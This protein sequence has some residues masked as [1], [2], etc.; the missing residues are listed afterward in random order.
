MV[1]KDKVCIIRKRFWTRRKPLLKRN[2]WPEPYVCTIT[3]HTK[4]PFMYSQNR[5]CAA[6]VPI[7]TFM[8]LCAIYIFPRSVHIFSCSRMG[9][10]VVRICKSLTDTGILKLGLRPCNSFSENICCEFS[11][12]CLCSARC[13][14]CKKMVSDFPVPSRDVT[15][16]TL[17]GLGII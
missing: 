4:I 13:L 10:L 3:L 11:V 12:L 17:P 7:S 9:R 15:C 14:T 6:S 1:S 5:N 2:K 8:C 16:Q